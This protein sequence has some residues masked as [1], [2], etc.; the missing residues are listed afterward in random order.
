MKAPRIGQGLRQPPPVGL[1]G[2]ASLTGAAEAPDASQKLRLVLDYLPCEAC[3]AQPVK[4][5]DLLCSVCHRLHRQVS[6][7]VATR[8][9]VIVERPDLPAPAAPVVIPP[10]APETPMV[11]VAPPP[12]EAP[13]APPPLPELEVVTEPFEEPAPPAP[14][15]EPVP[16]VEMQDEPEPE[17][18]ARKRF[19]LFRRKPA[20]PEP[21]PEE[22]TFDDV[23]G[24][25]PTEE[26]FGVARGEPEFAP[27]DVVEV[28]HE[29]PPAPEPEPQ[30]EPE[31]LAES[32]PEVESDF[33]FRPP[34]EEPEPAYTEPAYEEPEPVEEIALEPEPGE[35]YE[36]SPW[37]PREEEVLP[38]EPEPQP[39][40]APPPEPEE[41]VVEME[42]LP[43]EEEV[44]E[45]EI[46]E[47]EVIPA[48]VLEEEITPAAEPSSDLYRLRGFAPDHEE[49]L[50]AVGVDSLASL[51]GHDPNELAGRSG[52]PA[53]TLALWVQVADLVH[54]VGV[55]ID[56][57]SALVAA[58]IAGPR[59]LRDAT[60]E[61]IL[62]RV[63]AFGG[64]RLSGRD[65]KRW[66]RRA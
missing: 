20:E 55:P 16:A 50:R 34:E 60:E 40:W 52:L 19:G 14:E 8:T 13:P 35:T 21:A 4:D 66:K 18:P 44:L 45:A 5:Q 31:V 36:P 26:G 51:A 63:E 53:E 32:E 41:E 42:V 27:E 12:P 11:E 17:E 9:T 6:V 15:P 30:P 24:F 3:L 47:E 56:S 61:E 64:L 38:E 22:P 59:G 62:D 46:V 10:A 48:E 33:I 49:A 37:A 43:D 2:V 28:A 23:A 29:E 7:R 25:E 39:E 58:G 1:P 57:A 54:E 65:V